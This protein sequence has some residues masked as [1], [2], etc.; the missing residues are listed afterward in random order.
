MEPL[1]RSLKQIKAQIDDIRA[2]SQE[3]SHEVQ[4]I[5]DGPMHRFLTTID[6]ATT[7]LENGKDSRK[8]E[9]LNLGQVAKVHLVQAALL[10]HGKLSIVGDVAEFYVNISKLYIKPG[11]NRMDGLTSISPSEYNDQVS[12]FSRWCSGSTEE[13]EG[14]S[15][16]QTKIMIDRMKSGLQE[17]A[18]DILGVDAD[19]SD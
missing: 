7:A 11:I 10:S 17:I 4:T 2:L 5:T 19:D 3:V 9:T 12:E 1:I 18:R 15:R 8:T 13:I 16:K 14:S 6:N